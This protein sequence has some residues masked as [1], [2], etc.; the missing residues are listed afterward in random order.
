MYAGYENR[1]E[2]AAHGALTFSSWFGVGDP[3]PNPL[4]LICPTRGE[5]YSALDDLGDDLGLPPCRPSFDVLWFLAHGNG[6]A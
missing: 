3:D 6:G 5:A 2:V 1:P 4:I